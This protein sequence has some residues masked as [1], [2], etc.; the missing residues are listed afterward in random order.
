MLRPFTPLCYD[1]QGVKG[2][3]QSFSTSC[4]MRVDSEKTGTSVSYLFIYYLSTSV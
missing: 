1:E 2:G 4:H 3:L